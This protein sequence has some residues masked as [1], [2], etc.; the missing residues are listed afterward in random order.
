V[1][2]ERSPEPNSAA[3]EERLRA[4]SDGIQ[5]ISQQLHALEEQKRSV[6]P[7]DPR[8][9]QLAGLVRT[10][11]AELLELAS[12]EEAFANELSQAGADLEPIEQVPP[13]QHLKEILEEWRAVERE[14]ALA[15]PSSAEARALVERFE[16]LRGEY[17]RASEDKH[18]AVDGGA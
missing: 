8:F 14:L 4:A 6:E 13:R 9:V 11:A 7:N 1:A 16:Q 18:R 3:L 17:A 10:V 5:L 12:A 2:V 15:P